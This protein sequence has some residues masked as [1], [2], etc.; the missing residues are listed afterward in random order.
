[1]ERS[2]NK[3]LRA[4]F[5]FFLGV[6]LLAP[7]LAGA[8]AAPKSA[9]EVWKELEKLPPA[10][11]QKRLIEGAKSE[12]EMLWYTN[13]GIDNANNYI[14]AF[15]KAYPFVNAKVWRAKSRTIS[16]R[17]LTEARAGV[18]L[19][20]V[21]K[22]STNLLP[23]LFEQKLIGRYESPIRASYPAHA[24]GE[25]W[26]NLNYEFRVFA[27]NDRMISRQEAPKSWEELLDL[28][29]KG[30]I[31]F[32]ESSQEEVV[33]WL[34]MKGKEKTIA[35]FKKLSENLLI[36]RGRDTI[37]NLLAAGEAPLAV[38]VYPYNMETM[39]A[40][41]APVDWVAPDMIPGLLYPLTMVRYAPHPY[42]A[43]LFYDFLLS[44]AGQKMIASEGRIAADPKI[45][46]IFPKMKEL[47]QLLGT[48]RVHINT[49][50][51]APQF[52]NDSLKILDE[53]V[54]GRKR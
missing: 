10:E 15:K 7:A 28:K 17:F 21:V 40:Q 12:K 9:E 14:R 30:K 43:A 11:R 31:L 2:V 32:D 49:A 26:T 6:S 33:T 51:E 19:A 8:A 27:F 4:L 3:I 34:A 39:R 44:D 38:T 22:N 23:P 53:A 29:W 54:L 48:A 41:K 37:A 16:D 5:S 24:K 52:Y 50:E 18:Y 45:E 35:Y 36:R 1:M 13:T 20:D 47:K 46:P 42:S 25:L